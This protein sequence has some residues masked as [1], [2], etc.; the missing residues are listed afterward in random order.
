MP[1]HGERARASHIGHRVDIELGVAQ[2]VQR[3][4]EG[5]RD[6]VRGAGPAGPAQQM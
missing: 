3:D 2:P 6:R 5:T 1:V 4:D